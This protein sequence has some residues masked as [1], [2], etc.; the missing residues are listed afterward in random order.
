MGIDREG[1]TTSGSAASAEPS[2]ASAL[3]S[4]GGIGTGTS[5]GNPYIGTITSGETPY[6]GTSTFS[7]SS[8]T[9]GGKSGVGSGAGAVSSAVGI[10][11]GCSS[12]VAAPPPQL[13]VESAARA[14][15]VSAPLRP[16][17]PSG[18][19]TDD[20]DMTDYPKTRLLSSNVP[21]HNPERAVAHFG[22][23]QAHTTL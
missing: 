9:C 23:H 21:H 10:E 18:R 12:G 14:A 5:A 15:S 6:A 1:G 8:K 20:S 7:S 17:R 4:S 22:L 2:P 11:P 16:Q 13:A 3:P 19:G